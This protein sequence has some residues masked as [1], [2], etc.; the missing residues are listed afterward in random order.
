MEVKSEVKEEKKCNEDYFFFQ[1][2]CNYFQEFMRAVLN[3]LGLNHDGGDRGQGQADP[4][5]TAAD[6]PVAEA[7]RVAPPRPVI[8]GGSGPQTNTNPN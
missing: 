4:P 5:S 1:N 8:S 7:V 3:C 6:P 2:P